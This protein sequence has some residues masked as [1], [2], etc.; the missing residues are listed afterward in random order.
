MRI[1][2]EKLYFDGYMVYWLSGGQFSFYDN[3]YNWLK[4]IQPDDEY[5]FLLKL[6]E[7]SINE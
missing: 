4:T 5:T 6:R 7:E 1:Y 2:K 3:E